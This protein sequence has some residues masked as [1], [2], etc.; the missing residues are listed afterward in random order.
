MTDTVIIAGAGPTGLMLA[1]ELALQ[2]VPVV[3]VERRSGPTDALPGMAINAT[4]VDLLHQR[5]LMEHVGEYGFE[6]PRAHFAQ[7]WLDPV[8][9]P[10]RHGYNFVISQTNLVRV[11][12]E[13]AAKQGAEIRWE[14]E[15]VDLAQDAAGVRVTVRAPDGGQDV[16]A[17]RYLVG[18]DGPDSSVR[19]LAGIDFPGQDLP[20]LGIVGDLEVGEDHPLLAYLGAGE[21]P[22]GLLT[23]G[24]LEPGVVRIATAEFDLRPPDR[25]APVTV[26]ELRDSIRRLDG[27]E[28]GDATPRWLGRWDAATRQA[29]RYREGNVLLAGDAAHVH[30]PLGGQSMST[31]IE[32]AVNLGWKLAATI[33]GHAPTG[34]LDTYEAERYPV[35]ARA[36]RTTLAQMVL[37]HPLGHVAPLRELLTEMVELD[38]VNEFLVKLAY[39]LD[40]DY[41]IPAEEVAG[42]THPLLGRR[43]P[44]V[45]LRTAAGE[46]SLAEL[47]HPGRGILL[48]LGGEAEPVALPGWADRVDVVAAAGSEEIDAGLVLLR[49]D[50]RVAWAQPAGADRTEPTEGLR[51]AL[52]TWFGPAA[53]AVAAVGS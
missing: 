20:F 30:F 24:P 11:L 9:V 51:R 14:R 48:D 41:Q 38:Q 39:A 22:G 36:G 37:L 18:C 46:T 19:R 25:T 4:V 50:G 32:D 43:L 10:G 31:G 35:G 13:R 29:D 27:A 42:E 49:P 26:D 52:A 2:R 34:L 5:G 7:I 23:V 44:D 3:V 53:T 15:V 21:F 28:L 17:G 12:A 45:P 40:V 8:R 33:R 1:H 6:F 47:L 16:L